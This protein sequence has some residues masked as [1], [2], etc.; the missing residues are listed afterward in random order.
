MR[1]PPRHRRSRLVP[2]VVALVVVLAVAV[3]GWVAWG[4]IASRGQPASP[5]AAGVATGEPAASPSGASA[6]SSPSAAVSALEPEGADSAPGGLAV[7]EVVPTDGA[8]VGGEAVVLQGEGFTGSLIVRFGARDASE[9]QVLSP[10]TAR[11]TLP[12]GVP[13]PVD[14]EV[15]MPDGATARLDDAL[16]YVDRPP[17]VVMAVRPVLGSTAGGT[18]LTIVG[19]GFEPGAKVVVG[20]E[21]ARQVKVLDSTRITAV[22]PAHEEGVVDIVVRNPGMPAAILVQGYE[23]L[24]AP[25]IAGVLPE[26]IPE[27]GGVPIVVSGTGFE[28]GALV[29]LDGLPATDVQVVSATRLTA[30]APRGTLGPAVLIVVNPDQPAAVLADA[31]RYVPAAP[32]LPSSPTAP[33]SGSPPAVATPVPPGEPSPAG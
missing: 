29:T 5:V 13:G 12:P 3:V 7:R 9:V 26:E 22:S 15:L 6:A 20:G 25:T 28:S 33:S 11:V 24:P 32:P 27:T 17:R 8:I 31:V 14:V 21:R 4:L 10:Q 16:V 30:V 23:Y 2:R 19:T 18:A 1:R